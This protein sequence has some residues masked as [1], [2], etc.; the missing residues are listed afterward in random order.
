MNDADSSDTRT[1]LW[2][3]VQTI[4][5]TCHEGKGFDRLAPLF[6]DDFVI[7]TPGFTAHAKGRDTCLQ[8]YEDACSQIKIEKLDASDEHVDVFGST[9]VVSYKYD[10]IFEFQG[11]KH[12]D[13]GHEI[14]V[15][16]HD[17]QDWKVAWRTLV[18]G[19]RQSQTCPDRRS[20]A[21][22]RAWRRS[23]TDLRRSDGRPRRHAT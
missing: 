3:I 1:A 20:P 14:Y 7:V 13:D 2:Q 23:E 15:C 19:T 16:T 5:R 12:K 8:S 6:H 9:A 21:P 4:N 10:C 17:G 11:K 18:P 22:N